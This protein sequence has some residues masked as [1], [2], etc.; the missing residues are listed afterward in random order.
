MCLGYRGHPRLRPSFSG[1][2]EFAM[3][4]QG[5]T[6]SAGSPA[7]HD[8]DG[9][10]LDDQSGGKMKF[11]EEAFFSMCW[12]TPHDTACVMTYSQGACTVPGKEFDKG[13][14]WWTILQKYPPRTFMLAPAWFQSYR[15]SKGLANDLGLLTDADDP[16]TM[17]AIFA[18]ASFLQKLIWREESLDVAAT[19]RAW[20]GGSG[21]LVTFGAYTAELELDIFYQV[22]A[23]SQ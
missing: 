12:Y 1:P 23:H 8:P 9:K 2:S 15:P 10:P 6:A 3:V 5:P 20:L 16:D 4:T 7:N 13:L 18:P 22:T 19:V 14:E 11:K 21:K 17:V